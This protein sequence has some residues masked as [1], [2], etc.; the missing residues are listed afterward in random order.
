LE[1]D[2]VDLADWIYKF[3]P[4]SG[5]FFLSNMSGFI[6][7]E[8]SEQSQVFTEQGTRMPVTL[9]KTTPCYFIDLKTPEKHG[10]SAIKLGF[11]TVKKISKP[12]QGELN[13]AGI[14]APL[15][16]IREIRLD[17]FINNVKEIN[18]ENKI[19]IQIGEKKYFIGEEIKP[20]DMFKKGDEVYV[21][22]ITKAK[23][24]QGVV[25]RHKFSGGPK[26]HGQSDRLRA[27]GSIGQSTTP[28]RVYKGKRMSGRMG[29]NRVTVKG[30]HIFNI[31]DN[32]FSI[33]GLVPGQKGR[34]LE[35]KTSK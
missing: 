11:Q 16:F 22:G 6:L 19:G 13:K 29:H 7:G 5:V 32:G 10:Y 18:E 33:L 12:S 31:E 15:H 8:K 20:S 34:L 2:V 1:K 4:Q 25:K 21:T 17:K 35:I 26:T 23:G 14:K 30:L 24:F 3:R 9:I 28:G 27:P